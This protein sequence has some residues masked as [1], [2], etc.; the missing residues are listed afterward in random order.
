MIKNNAVSHELILQ[1]IGIAFRFLQVTVNFSF[2][3]VA[4]QVRKKL[5]VGLGIY[6]KTCVNAA[7]A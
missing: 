5:M 6:P 2:K 4:V 1:R 3:F 7:K